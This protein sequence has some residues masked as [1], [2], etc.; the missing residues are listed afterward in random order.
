MRGFLLPLFAAA[1]L[2]YFGTCALVLYWGFLEQSV[3]ALGGGA[4]ML[5][6]GI[7]ELLELRKGEGGGP[8]L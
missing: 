2:V 7:A 3:F 1:L 8:L 5:L 6:L 4:L